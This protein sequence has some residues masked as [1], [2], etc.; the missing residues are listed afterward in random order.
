MPRIPDA[1]RGEVVVYE[2]PDGQVRVDVQFE[3][4]R[5]WFTIDQMAELFGRHRTAI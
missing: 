3:Q 5:V 2:S 4:E 1:P